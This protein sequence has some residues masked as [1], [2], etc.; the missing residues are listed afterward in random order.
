[1]GVGVGVGVGDSVIA[2]LCVTA[3]HCSGKPYCTANAIVLVLFPLL[4][5]LPATVEPELAG[6]GGIRCPS[7]PTPAPPPTVGLKRDVVLLYLLPERAR[8][9]RGDENTLVGENSVSL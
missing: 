9:P 7:Y 8:T 4:L 5:L 6:I 3:A 2:G 1:M